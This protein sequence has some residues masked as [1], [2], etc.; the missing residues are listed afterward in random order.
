MKKGQPFLFFIVCVLLFGLGIFQYIN[1]KRVIITDT[2]SGPGNVIYEYVVERNGTETADKIKIKNTK[3]FYE[4]YGYKF[5]I[6]RYNAYSGQNEMVY[7]FLRKDENDT[8]YVDSVK[9]ESSFYK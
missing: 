3:K 8:W 7:F 1:Y 5:D 6:Y 9:T 2:S 4:E